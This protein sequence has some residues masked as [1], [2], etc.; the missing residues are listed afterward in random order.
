MG[1]AQS[2][3]ENQ[4]MESKAE[5][6]DSPDVVNENEGKKMENA[7][8][9]KTIDEAETEINLD[10]EKSKGDG[11]DDVFTENETNEKEKSADT[12]AAPK[13]RRPSIFD[14][15]LNIFS[16][17]FNINKQED[18]EPSNPKQETQDDE[19]TNEHDEPDKPILVEEDIEIVVME[20]AKPAEDSQE[21]LTEP[22]PKQT[23]IERLQSFF[24]DSSQERGEK[25]GGKVVVYNAE[26]H[27]AT[28][29]TDP[30]ESSVVLDKIDLNNE[31]EAAQEGTSNSC[32]EAQN[33]NKGTEE[34]AVKGKQLKKLLPCCKQNSEN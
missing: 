12:D 28:A 29:E 20:E 4:E 13:D 2:V 21:K 19:V 14:S 3:K 8:E 17:A 18:T 16:E 15:F 11:E 9:K 1:D 6:T 32:E 33:S 27:T 23:L 5:K 7:S 25:T 34:T 30:K 31:N 10:E 22:K 24:R 26:D